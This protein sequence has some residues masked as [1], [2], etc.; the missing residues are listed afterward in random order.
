MAVIEL[1]KPGQEATTYELLVTVGNSALLVNGIVGTQLL[2]AFKGQACENDDADCGSNTINTSSRQAFDDSHGPERFRDYTLVLCTVSVVA[3]TAF[4]GFLPKS[5]EE[6]HEW[7]AEG[8][9]LGRSE[10]RGYITLAM[11]TVTVVVSTLEKSWCSCRLTS[12]FV[13]ACSTASR[14]PSCC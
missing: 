9:R 4:V 8:E 14:Q 11:V 7:K 2:S 10:L 6:C 3:V 12:V 13:F 1:A 5:K